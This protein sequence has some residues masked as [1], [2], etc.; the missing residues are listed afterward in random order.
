MKWRPSFALWLI[1]LLP[2]LLDLPVVTGRT[3]ADPMVFTAAV[4]DTINFH[5]SYPWIDPNVGF[6]AQALGK[7]SADTL[8]H[9]Q[10]PWWN[11]YNGVGL[12]LAAEAQPGSLFLPFVL[13][14]HFQSGVMWLQ[15]ILQAMAGL[16][17]YAFL[18]KLG[19]TELAATTG[20]LLYELNGTFAWLGLTV[21]AP[22]AFLPMLLLGTES[23]LQRVNEDRAGG[24]L[25]IPVALAWS[26]Y[27]G[28]PETAY[29]DGLFVALWVLFRLPD[30]K[31]GARFAYM[32]KLIPAVAIGLA[33]SIL[34][35][36]PFARYV[37]LAV[38]GGHDGYSSHIALLPAAASL[39]FIPGLFGP[40]FRFDDPAGVINLVWDRIGG[41]L[42][43]LQLIV[44]FL[45]VLLR[46]K[47]IMFVLFAW[48]ALCWC[49]TFDIWPISHLLD[50]VPLMKMAAFYRYS[51]PSWE[52]AGV[53]IVC[54]GIDAVQR[55][56]LSKHRQIVFAA[57]ATLA[58]LI[59]ALWLAWPTILTLW[60][61]HASAHYIR[62]AVGRLILAMGAVLLALFMVRRWSW[63]P[64]LLAALLVVDAALAFT[65]PLHSAVSQVRSNHGGLDY[66]RQHIGLQRTFTLGPLAPNYGAYFR[67]AQINHNYVPLTAD[68]ANYVQR[69]LD[70]GVIPLLFTGGPLRMQGFGSPAEQLQ[71]HLSAYEDVGVK[72]VLAPHGVDPFARA[73]EMPTDYEGYHAPLQLGT[74]SQAVLYWQIPA[75]AYVRNIRAVSV[76]LGNYSGRS[77]GQ[78][79]VEVCL[80]GATCVDG[81]RALSESVDNTAFEVP[82]DHELT[83]ATAP[84]TSTIP[85]ILSFHQERQSYPVVLW[86]NGVQRAHASEVS[87]NG[88]PKGTAPTISLLYTTSEVGSSDKADYKLAYDGTDMSIYEL[89]GAK[90]YF[91]ASNH[92]C[93]IRAV[94]REHANVHC[95]GSAQLLRR[96]AFFPGWSATVNGDTVPVQRTEGIFQ[97]VMLHAGDN[98]VLFTYRPSHYWMML[99]LFAGGMFALLLGVLQELGR[100][101]H[102]AVQ[103]V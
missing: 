93:S 95:Q 86:I 14:Y 28:F 92:T 73:V 90:P 10:L 1:I 63:A 65:A 99:M 100:S 50:A 31:T 78:L 67:I 61:D 75:Q 43:A 98:D 69:R 5:G 76:T 21:T 102:D 11:P 6:Q 101:R 56:M 25:L 13:L 30:V 47:R 94:T 88:Y 72:Y 66:L 19:L 68:W 71:L 57:A 20:G 64:G 33:C 12:P 91:E 46:P 18:R 16:C 87:L 58:C 44:M 48:I 23:L 2:L 54:I 45:A 38:V 24:W 42:P 4:G 59:A 103:S 79:D 39:T 96:E 41:Y 37:S 74:G 55:G 81:H 84:Q 29:I 34:Q 36:L 27:S 89:F 97:S 22:I 83:V 77:D 85:L 9:G 26:I 82:L 60:A 49:K 7:L 70:P 3:T 80:Q 8:L 52:F 53:L 40:I 62:V 32:R 17:T 15:I 35:I 51:P